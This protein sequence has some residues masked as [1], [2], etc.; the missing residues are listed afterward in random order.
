MLLVVYVL[1]TAELITAIFDDKYNLEVTKLHKFKAG[2]MSTSNTA[3]ASP[4]VQS[5]TMSGDHDKSWTAVAQTNTSDTDPNRHGMCIIS[6]SLVYFIC[7]SG[8]QHSW[9]KNKLYRSY[10]S[11]H[12][13]TCNVHLQKLGPKSKLW[14]LL[15]MMFSPFLVKIKML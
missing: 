1:I 7:C 15:C 8:V 11:D 14:H 10:S 3:M 2:N 13:I 9:T 5:P 4:H 6:Q 12:S